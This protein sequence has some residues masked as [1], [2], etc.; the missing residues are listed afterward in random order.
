MSNKK[1]L[2]VVTSG[3]T[4][5]YIDSVRK[6]TNSSSGKLGCIIS[7]EI[8][9]NNNNNRVIYIHSK[10]A[11][12]PNHPNVE[13]I[14]ITTTK[15]LELAISDILKNNT[16]DVFIHSM[17]VSDYS[18]KSVLDL[19][20]LKKA[21]ESSNKKSFEEVL[22]MCTIDN[23]KK[24]S[25]KNKSPLIYLKE[26]PKIISL[27]K[28]I[29]PF[30]FLVGFKLLDNISEEEL[31]DVGFDLLRK[32]RCNLVLANDISKIR[33]GNHTGMIIYP[34]KNKTIVNGKHAIAK[35]LV[36]EI[37]NRAFVKHPK[38][39]CISNSNNISDNEATAMKEVGEILYKMNVLPE[40]I[41][42]NR[43]DKV[44]TYGNLSFKLNNSSFYITGRNVHKGKLN[45][46]DICLVE[47]VDEIVDNSVYCNVNYHGTIK[48]S[49][50]SSIHFKIYEKTDY[51]HI[52]HIHT[53]RLFL[54]DFPVTSYNYPC[55]SMEERDAI[56][57]FILNN[58]S[59]KII[60][61]YK[62]GLIILGNS[63][64]DCL[65]E[66][67][68]LYKKSIFIDYDDKNYNTEFL[69]HIADV[70]ANFIYNEG[71]IYPIKY[72]GKTIGSVWEK[73]N[74]NDL[75]FAL[76]LNKK[77]RNKKYNLVQKYLKT[78]KTNNLF[79]H[80]KKECNISNLYIDKFNFEIINNDKDRIILKRS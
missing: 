47:S 66:I 60:Q 53:N 44:G 48:P 42:H 2:F 17:A 18:V 10:G 75:H 30:T 58:P 3:G 62:H 57:E 27:I 9:K 64:E 33:K 12:K 45:R 20:C 24:I 31:F 59:T 78:N 71:N 49:I 36:K 34:E 16:V 69:D 56:I 55:G 37:Y 8:L 68:N 46:N 22:N 13:H 29:S 11:V 54:G 43:T 35:E 25:S 77:E 1:I 19:E 79:L 14:E 67:S 28:K 52:V 76:Y 23:T 21:F 50:D 7:E 39:I 15:D 73:R 5:E 61:L 38:S 65:N 4:S 40:V 80:T 26:N 6:I 63:F 74:N 51:T 70:K 72:C 41:N 32:N